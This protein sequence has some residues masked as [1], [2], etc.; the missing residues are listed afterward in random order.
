MSRGEHFKYFQSSPGKKMI[1]ALT[2]L[3]WAGFV[4][5]HMLGNF[6][7]FVS[8]DAYNAYSHALI[9]NKIILVAEAVLVLTIAFHAINGILLTL[10]NSKSRGSEKYAMQAK[11]EKAV[12]LASKTMIYHGTLLMIFIVTHLVG[13]KFGPYYETT[14]NGVVMRDI[15]RLVVEVLSQPMPLAWY[16]VSMVALGLHL[17]HGF[18]SLF[19]SLGIKSKSNDLLIKKVSLIY[20]AVVALGFISQPIY[21]YLFLAR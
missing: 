11:G 20:G 14:V 8:A 18:G 2:G 21:I 4:L 17:S 13:L 7:I 16:L 12:T 3:I 15:Y 9:T 19:Q 5:T 6:L 1:M 10:Y